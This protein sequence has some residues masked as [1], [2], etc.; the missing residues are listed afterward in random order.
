M[1]RFISHISLTSK[2][3][4]NHIQKCHLSL[5]AANRKSTVPCQYNPKHLGKYNHTEIHKVKCDLQGADCENQRCLSL[6]GNEIHRESIGHF[7]SATTA[8]VPV[9]EKKTI[10]NLDPK[11]N[12]KAQ[13]KPQN[14][15]LYPNAETTTLTEVVPHPD[16][17]T[18][19]QQ[20]GVSEKVFNATGPKAK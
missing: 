1:Q 6:C 7:T 10:I 5:E 2:S 18:F 8:D 15:A 16:G 19:L 20:H 11:V 17:T 9:S 4:L 14:A 12:F 3:S 13:A